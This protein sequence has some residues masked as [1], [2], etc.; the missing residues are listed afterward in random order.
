MWKYIKIY[1]WI[2]P[3]IALLYEIRFEKGHNLIFSS[4][5]EFMISLFRKCE[6]LKDVIMWSIL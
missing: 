4:E 2:M 1:L 5:D 3:L 6:N